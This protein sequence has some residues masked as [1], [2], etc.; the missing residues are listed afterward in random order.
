MTGFGRAEGSCSERKVAVEVR[1]LNSKQLDLMVKLPA[2]YR[3]RDALV[4]G[5]ATRAIVRGKAE[6]VVQLDRNAQQDRAHIDIDLVRSRYTALQAVA[7]AVAPEHRTD[8]LGLVLRMP[9][10]M[11]AESGPAGDEEWDQVSNLIDQALEAF[12]AFRVAEGDKLEKDLREHVSNI[13]THLNAV[14]QWDGERMERTRERL[15]NRLA[16]LKLE[17][18]PERFEQELVLHLEKSDINEEVVRLGTHCAYFLETLGEGDQQ[19]R[20]LGFIAQEMGREINTI[21]SK[22]NDATM[23]RTV[24]GMK[25][26]LEKIKEQV[27]N[28]L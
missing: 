11:G 17:V 20:K 1:S 24:V 21:G 25:D 4:R 9:D 8:I 19:G 23:Q 7:D 3:D 26:E 12:M 28:V 6:V 22:C 2:P 16:E 14:S 18:T 10:V 27:L 15:R 5:T 13:R